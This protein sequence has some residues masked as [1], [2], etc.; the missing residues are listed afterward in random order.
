MWCVVSLLKKNHRTLYEE[1]MP[2]KSNPS[3]SQSSCVRLQSWLLMYSAAYAWLTLENT[4]AN[5]FYSRECGDECDDQALPN[6]FFLPAWQTCGPARWLS[7]TW[8]WPSIS[9]QRILSWTLQCILVTTWCKAHE[10][11]AS[12]STRTT[13]DALNA[14]KVLEL[15]GWIGYVSFIFHRIKCCPILGGKKWEI[16]TVPYFCSWGHSGS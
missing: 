8:V 3:T 1:H 2:P 14:I 6:R 10:R 9:S 7:L 5:L 15:N 16:W 4:V 12:R 11:S 13:D